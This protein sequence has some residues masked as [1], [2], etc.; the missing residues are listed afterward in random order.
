MQEQN[1][2]HTIY[3][4]DIRE[5]LDELSYIKKMSTHSVCAYENDIRKFIQWLIDKNL[6][7]F[8]VS[9]KDM[10]AYIRYCSLLK[11]SKAT[12]NRNISSL[13]QFFNR[14][15][16]VKKI[17]KNPA[18]FLESFKKK[19]SLPLVITQEQIK[20]LFSF[21]IN[22]FLDLRDKTLFEFLYSTGC[23][24]SEALSLNAKETY[25][26][27]QLNIRGKGDK[28]RS[29]FI[30]ATLSHRIKEYLFEREKKLA[31]LKRQETA[32][33][34]N[35]NGLRLTRNGASWLLKKRLQES[36]SFSSM[37]AHGFRHAFAT[38][39][40][41]NGLDVRVVQE[42]LGHSSISTTQIYTHI[43]KTHLLEKY[44]S[45]HPRA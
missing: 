38:H 19:I 43:S 41:D 29:V 30:T 27:S 11:Y 39:L 5:F 44:K 20:E 42:L 1:T 6:S 2:Q 10:R 13:R 12:L 4:E 21:P 7:L 8:S 9:Y 32:L 15:I 28:S 33:F 34:I 18:L 23:R 14:L 40:L 45:A 25:N 36:K 37:S 17:E 31:L 26:A 3:E 22:N 16:R 24:I 35:D